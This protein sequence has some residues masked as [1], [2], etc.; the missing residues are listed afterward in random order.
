MGVP[1]STVFGENNQIVLSSSGGLH[2][3]VPL[4]TCMAI[5]TDPLL[6]I[7]PNINKGK[8][9]MTHAE[10][11]ESQRSQTEKEMENTA[12]FLQM[13]NQVN[14]MEGSVKTQIKQR[15]NSRT[16]EGGRTNNIWSGSKQSSHN[17]L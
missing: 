13:P 11:G 10:V 9:S 16:A 3:M 12:N 14:T 8:S 7:N 2:Q 17:G 15:K 5:T 4:S 1:N 6:E